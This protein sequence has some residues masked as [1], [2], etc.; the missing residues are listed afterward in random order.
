MNDTHPYTAL[1]VAGAP[2]AQGGRRLVASV[3]LAAA[4]L[5]LGPRAVVA[6]VAD[7]PDRSPVTQGSERR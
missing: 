3:L 6:V 1:S 7:G 2:P 4:V 5:A